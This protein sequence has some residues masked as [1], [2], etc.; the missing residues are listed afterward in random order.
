M[1]A[2]PEPQFHLLMTALVLASLAVDQ[3][4]PKLLH[5]WNMPKVGLVTFTLGLCWIALFAAHRIANLHRRI[6]VLQD[7]LERTA[8][9][10]DAL[11]DD[12]RARRSL[13]LR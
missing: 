1:R 6:E 5:D 10:T 7:Q 9:R 12:A 8:R 11:E 3:E 4:M 13:P 2:L